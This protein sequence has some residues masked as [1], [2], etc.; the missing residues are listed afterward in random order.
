MFW[1][2]LHLSFPHTTPSPSNAFLPADITTLHEYRLLHPQ[3]LLWDNV[4]VT[5][6]KDEV[7]FVLYCLYRDIRVYIKTG[8]VNKEKMTALIKLASN[9][10][11]VG[12]VAI[13]ASI[14]LEFEANELV[15][16]MNSRDILI[17]HLTN[18]FF[19]NRITKIARVKEGIANTSII[20]THVH[21]NCVAAILNMY[22]L[23]QNMMH[24]FNLSYRIDATDYEIVTH[25]AD[26][27]YFKAKIAA[28]HCINNSFICYYM[29]T[30]PLAIWLM[31]AMNFVDTANLYYGCVPCS[32][33]PLTVVKK[34]PIHKPKKVPT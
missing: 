1:P 19:D 13:I 20:H 27:L 8:I 23:G 14:R 21:N 15:Q 4:T 12:I 31:D 26:S 30:A 29:Q 33:E 11:D 5:K 7:Y 24:H 10:K 25:I 18:E 22:E 16:E 34:L 17:S 3:P 28:C 9:N 6:Q 32:T 2:V